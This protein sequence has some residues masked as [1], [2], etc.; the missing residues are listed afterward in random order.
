M[1]F[2]VLIKIRKL[3]HREDVI[4][5]KLYILNVYLESNLKF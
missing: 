4:Y 1:Q 2:Y 5:L 3:R